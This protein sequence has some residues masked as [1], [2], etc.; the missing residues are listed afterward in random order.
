MATP[1]LEN[2]GVNGAQMCGQAK[3]HTQRSHGE[4][5]AESLDETS[6]EREDSYNDQVGDERPFSAEAVGEEIGRAHV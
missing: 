1:K 3:R 2:E 4:E 5:L 6:S